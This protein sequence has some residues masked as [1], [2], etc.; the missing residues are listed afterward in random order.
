MGPVPRRSRP[1]QLNGSCRKEYCGTRSGLVSCRNLLCVLAQK[2]HFNVRGAATAQHRPCAG[3]GGTGYGRNADASSAIVQLIPNER[4]ISALTAPGLF[5]TDGA[6]KDPAMRNPRFL[7]F[8]SA[9]GEC[10]S[11]LRRIRD[12]LSVWHWRAA[13]GA[14]AGRS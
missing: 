2:M 3:S 7:V 1:V 9:R 10:L 4:S 6:R 5:L 14:R 11:D 8:R 12:G 13:Y